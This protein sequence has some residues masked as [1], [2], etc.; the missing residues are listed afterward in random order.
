MEDKN[1]DNINRHRQIRRRK[2]KARRRKARIRGV[3]FLLILI[4][5]VSFGIKKIKDWSGSQID[6]SQAKAGQWYILRDMGLEKTLNERRPENL[7]NITENIINNKID[8]RLVKGSNHMNVAEEYAFDAGKINDI[9]EGKQ[10][11]EGHNKWAFLTFDD[12][13]N[14]KITPRVLDVLK[15]NEVPATFFVVGRS[16]TN[17]KRDVLM[18][19]L[20]EGHGIALH[21]F[22]HDYKALYPGRVGNET[23]IIKDAKLTQKAL[24][25]VISPDFYSSVWRYPGGHMSWSGLDEADQALSSLDINWIDWNTLSGDAEAKSVRPTTAAGMVD[26]MKKSLKMNEEENVAVVLMH[27]AENKSLTVEALPHIIK[28]LRDQGYSFGILK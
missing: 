1:I 18:R 22:Y 23:A 9:I 12:G 3:A 14:H 17:N 24:Q 8:L 4:L 19:E 2:I 28:E 10:K 7:A 25:D 11:Y 21:S 20:L 5:L 6:V 13:P 15:E 26:Y 16:V 27:D